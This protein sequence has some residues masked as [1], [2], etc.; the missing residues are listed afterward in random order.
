M[1]YE[2]ITPFGTMHLMGLVRIID[3]DLALAWP[4][5]TP[6]AAVMALRDR[7]FDVV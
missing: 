2:V 5:R 4:R 3:R 6:H 1:L 7:G